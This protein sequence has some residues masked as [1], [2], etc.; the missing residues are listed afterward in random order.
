MDFSVKRTLLN[1]ILAISGG[2]TLVSG[3]FLFFRHKSHL[4]VFL[5]EYGSLVFAA[6]CLVHLVLNRKALLK[7]LRGRI[8]AWAMVGILI[9][10]TLIMACSATL[11][12][13]GQSP[14]RGKVYK[15]RT[16]LDSTSLPAPMEFVLETGR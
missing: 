7:S 12:N 16:Q 14:K 1:P 3:L 11:K 8:S 13:K 5:H 4:I 6:G 2:T 10:V 15:H 9:V